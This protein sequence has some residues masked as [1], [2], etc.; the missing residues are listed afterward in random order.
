LFLLKL[1]EMGVGPSSEDRDGRPASVQWRAAIP[2]AEQC[3]ILKLPGDVVRSIMSNMT[4][5]DIIRLSSTCRS[6]RAIGF[7]DSFWQVLCRRDFGS[8]LVS[9]PSGISFLEYVLH[10]EFR[11]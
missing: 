5:G 2:D 11:S 4:V 8:D 7:D 1:A 6:L 3:F 10:R 9:N